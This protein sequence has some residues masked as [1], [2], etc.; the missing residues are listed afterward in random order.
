MKAFNEFLGTL[1]HPIKIVIAG[2]HELTFD[3]EHYPNLAKRFHRFPFDAKQS[4]ALL[5]NA[6]Y[7]EDQAVEVNKI[8]IYGSGVNPN[9]GVCKYV[10]F[11][12]GYEAKH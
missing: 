9:V 11:T 1:P 4:K 2:N 12:N 10:N 8:K 7:L 3:V 6:L 5:T